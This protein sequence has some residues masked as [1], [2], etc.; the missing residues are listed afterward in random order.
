MKSLKTYISLY[1]YHVTLHSPLLAEACPQAFSAK[2]SPAGAVHVGGNGGL[3]LAAWEVTLYVQL[4]VQSM[5]CCCWWWI[6]IQNPELVGCDDA[7]C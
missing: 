6:Y 1:S 4:V 2:S 5:S 3:V 7:I